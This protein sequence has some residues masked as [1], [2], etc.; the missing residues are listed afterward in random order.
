MCPVPWSYESDNCDVNRPGLSALLEEQGD[1]YCYNK[2]QEMRKK[3][4]LYPVSFTWFVSRIAPVK[5]GFQTT[6][7]FRKENTLK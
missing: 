1:G 7:F 2:V 5:Y 6:D 4:Q 3:A